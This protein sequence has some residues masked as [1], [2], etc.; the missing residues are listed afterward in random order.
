MEITFRKPN[1]DRFNI[2]TIKNSVTLRLAKNEMKNYLSSPVAYVV[3][4][5]FVVIVS[6]LLFSVYQYLKFGTGDLGD[7]FS[8]I[9]F[10]FIIIVPALTMGSIA[11][12]RQTGTLEFILTQPISAVQ[13]ILSKFLAYTA[14]IILMVGLT[15]PFTFIIGTLVP[16]DFGQVIMQYIGAIFLGMS[17]A[18]IGIA[19]SSFFKSEIVS[20][21]V[22]LLV[23]ALFVITGTSLLNIFPLQFQQF[24]E[25][26]SLLSH[27][28]SIS[29]GVLDLRDVLYFVALIISF[30]TISYFVIIRDKFPKKDK[31][32]ENSRLA[33]VI[34]LVIAVTIGYF[35]QLIPG[36]IDFTSN[37]KYTLSEGS[38]NTI[39]QLQ[40][41]FNITFFA[42]SNLPQEFQPMLRETDDLLRDFQTRSSGKINIIRK[43]PQIDVTA[44]DEATRFG[45][46]E[47]TFQVNTEDTAQ[48]A[49]G[50]FGIGFQYLDNVGGFDIPQDTSNLEYQ[51]T[52]N[53][54]KLAKINI[55]TIGFL[56]NNVKQS[57]TASYNGFYQ[58]LSELFIIED[59]Q[60]TKDN[61]TISP[62]IKAVI[63]P[64][65]SAKFDQEVINKLKEY[66]NLGGSIFLLTDPLEAG[67]SESQLAIENPNSLRD[68]FSDIGIEVNNSVAYDLQSNNLVGINSGGMVYSVRY[69]FWLIASSTS[70]AKEV[71]KVDTFLPLLW[72]SD[73]RLDSGKFGDN[74]V[75]Q[76][77]RTTAKS[78][79]ATPPSANLAIDQKFTEKDN[80]GVKVVSVSVENKNGGRAI[81]VGDSDFLTD[82]ILSALQSRQGQD[83]LATGFATTS[84][85]WLTKDS[86]I[87]QIAAKNR[88]APRLVVDNVKTFTIVGF[89]II[90]P[91]VVVMIAGS[92]VFYRRKR[93]S[94][95][96]YG[97]EKFAEDLSEEEI[98][99]ENKE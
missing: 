85:E 87:S 39:N 14:L 15:I 69:P 40:D 6:I 49:K 74:K 41:I 4:V 64:G 56:S 45:L 19:V 29:R 24:A 76:L 62:N 44:K 38:I 66:F 17:F 1:L 90:L 95:M 33:V 34:I 94:T 81:V 2:S 80:D 21:L 35:G 84:L 67:Q 97:E 27:Y 47:L 52:K 55:Q 58:S 43:D 8:S 53:I 65:P 32:L 26:F 79:V 96:S 63:I 99:E 30:I 22:S 98:S 92:V 51:I 54:K 13:F 37:G 42:P 73:I 59:V 25:K 88:T 82:D 16:L 75:I 60:L 3:M 91:V 50:Y 36:R 7:L 57:T 12:E 20:L 23:S 5:L 93:L 71:L 9:G 48:T 11:R 68:F 72:S 70:E 86:G 28:Q 10:G 89:G 77:F 18:G 31:Y 78:N 46:Q 61:L 83:Q